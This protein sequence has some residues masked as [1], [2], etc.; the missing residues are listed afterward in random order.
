MKG[1]SHT[2]CTQTNPLYKETALRHSEQQSD[3]QA[4]QQVDAVLITSM[5]PHNNVGQH[6]PLLQLT[7]MAGG[8]VWSALLAKARTSLL[9]ASS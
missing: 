1:L 7:S 8:T 4:L 3:C 5:C 2:K 6:A 9:L